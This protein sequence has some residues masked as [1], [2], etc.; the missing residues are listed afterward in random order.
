MELKTKIEAEKDKQELLITRDFDLPLELLFK[1]YAESELLE[2]W[3][4]TKV[5]KLENKSHGSYRLKLQTLNGINMDSMELYM[6]SFPIKRSP[7]HL[8][9]RIRHLASSLSSLSSNNSRMIPA[10]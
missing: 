2:Q 4:G 9:W 5:L 8:K 3:M 7:G 6:S 10:G 1:A